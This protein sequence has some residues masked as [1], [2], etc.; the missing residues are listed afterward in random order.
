MVALKSQLDDDGDGVVNSVDQ[1]PKHQTRE[2]MLTQVVVSIPVR[3]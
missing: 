2:L 3:R 1:C